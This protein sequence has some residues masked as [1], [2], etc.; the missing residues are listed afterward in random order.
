[1]IRFSGTTPDHGT[2][3]N[4]RKGN[5]SSNVAGGNYGREG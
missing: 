5:E 4:L 3:W 2:I 1:L